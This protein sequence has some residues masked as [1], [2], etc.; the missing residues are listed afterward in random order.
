MTTNHISDSIT[1]L[2]DCVAIIKDVEADYMETESGIVISQKESKVSSL[3]ATVIAVGPGR[4]LENGETTTLPFTV[5]DRVIYGGYAGTEVE[6]DGVQFSI[7]REG[8]ILA[9]IDES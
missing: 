9:I 7:V 4:L 8:D 6:H 3:K 2:Q 1:P 5:G